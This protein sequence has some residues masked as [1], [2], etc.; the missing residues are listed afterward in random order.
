MCTDALAKHY[1]IASP[2]LTSAHWARLHRGPRLPMGS[3][4]ARVDWEEN[5]RSTVTFAIG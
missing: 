1:G 4:L 3:N 2:C 5:R